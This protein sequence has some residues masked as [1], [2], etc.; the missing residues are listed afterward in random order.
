MEVWIVRSALTTTSPPSSGGDTVSLLQEVKFPSIATENKTEAR[1]GLIGD[2]Y[3][4]DTRIN[5][6]VAFLLA[7]AKNHDVNALVSMLDALL[8]E[9]FLSPNTLCLDA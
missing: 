8:A 4:Y 5:A 1:K 7:L 9:R 6:C 2:V 3:M